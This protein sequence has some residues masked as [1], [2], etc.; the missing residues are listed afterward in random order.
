MRGPAWGQDWGPHS[1][2]WGFIL[3]S[4][5]RRGRR[6]GAPIIRLSVGVC[7]ATAV[8]FIAAGLIVLWGSSGLAGALSGSETDPR[9]VSLGL[10][11]K[12]VSHDNDVSTITY[13]VDTYES[14]PDSLTDFRWG[15]DKDG[16][17]S[18]D[19]FISVEYDKKLIGSVEDAAENKIANA[20]IS[21]P[22]GNALRISFSRAVLG[23]VDAY[24]YSVRALNDLNGNGEA[25]PGE[26]DIAPNGGLPPYHH[27]LD[28]PVSPAAPT[29]G[30]APPGTAETPSDAASPPSA[31]GASQERVAAPA[32]PGG[33]RS[34]TEGAPR[35]DVVEVRTGAPDVTPTP[36]PQAPSVDRP[37]EMAK[38]GAK[39]LLLELLGVGCLT[40]GMACRL[41]SRKRT[42][43]ITV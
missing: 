31:P 12:T 19:L 36:A 22:A 2:S 35:P 13:A 41:C 42:K 6:Q 11:L 10:D 26:V 40:L 27:R 7:G 17:Q 1:I 34:A 3:Q 43:M 29:S 5:L 15:I 30:S 9:D 37:K 24:S 18:S 14:F 33:P 4:Y 23:G 39:S 20:T 32:A 25:D 28:P 38:T 16:D 8:R 21:R